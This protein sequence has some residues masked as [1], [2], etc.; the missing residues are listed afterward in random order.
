MGKRL[1]ALPREFNLDIDK[2]MFNAVYLPE[3][4]KIHEREVYYGGTGSGKSFFISQKLALQM[5]LIE[6]RNLVCLRR[7]KTDCISSCWSDV[8]GAL[9]EFKLLDFWDV[10]ENPD[11]VMINRINGNQITFEGVDNIEDIKSIKFFNKVKNKR[12]N[13]TD[14]WYEE[15]NAEESI[16]TIRE[17]ERR[18]RDPHAVNR[19]IISF[20]PVS[21]SHWLYDYVTKE[22]PQSDFDVMILKTTYKDNAHYPNAKLLES[23]KFTSPYNYQVYTL[24]NWGTEGESVF[25][26]DLIQKRLNF[27]SDKKFTSY[28]FIYDIGS[29]KFPVDSSYQL[30]ENV[31]GDITVFK[32]PESR[33]PYIVSVDPSGEGKDFYAADVMDNITGEQVAVYHSIEKP[34]V[35]IWQVYGLCRLYN[36][37]LYVPEINFDGAW[38]I[39]TFQMMD[40][41]NIYKRTTKADKTHIRKEDRYGWRTQPDNRTLMINDMILW[42]GMYMDNINDAETLNEMLTFTKQSKKLHGMWMGAEA[43]THDDLVMAFAICLQG[44]EQQSMELVATGRKIEGD[45]W[46]RAELQDAYDEGRF[47]I[48]TILMYV[49]TKGCYGEDYATKFKWKGM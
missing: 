41:T 18:I 20:N 43:G 33:H 1:V 47:D 37:A 11:H 49:K 32:M 10:K 27:L 21:R 46:T 45:G 7:Q 19:I 30:V 36:D 24:G 12:S 25:N 34:E 14:V 5:T 9:S 13:L 8:K 28:S 38:T 39:K 48:N 17:L 3:L 2:K 31:V 35:C 44:R 29:N 6:D 26:S 23:Y 16:E 4:D 15:V 42:T 22:L 40:Y